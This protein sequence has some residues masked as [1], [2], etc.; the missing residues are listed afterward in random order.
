[1]LGS[2]YSLVAVGYTLV[3]GVLG[4]LNLA[5]PEVFMFGAF[6]G[7]VF[8][9]VGFPLY[10]SI[11]LAMAGAGL[12]SIV[13]ERICFRPLKRAHLLAPLLS[14]IAFAIFLQNAAITIWGSE[15]SRFPS[16]IKFESY[17]VG[18]VLISSLQIIILATAIVLMGGLDIFIRKT[19]V[20]RG[21]RA[22]AENP[23]AAKL[24]GISP[25]RIIMVSFFV[26]GAMAGAAGIL[27]GILFSSISPHM[28][29]F[30]GLKGI[31]VMIVGGLG[32]LR[33]AMIAGIFLGIAEVISVAYISSLFRDAIVYGILILVLFI[34]PEGLFAPS[35]E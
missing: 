19:K 30:H 31:A 33:G 27:L 5:H 12:L 23:E 11:V 28:G 34:R 26:S 2:T 17:A 9:K 4:M 1:M 20:G 29:T 18:P 32:N 24:F 21:M 3:F 16:I 10:V 14:T 22:V 13:V 6:L 25:D 35:R 8:V 15:P 7:L